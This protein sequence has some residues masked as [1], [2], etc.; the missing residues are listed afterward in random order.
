MIKAPLAFCILATLTLF[1]CGSSYGSTHE[2]VDGLFYRSPL[3]GK[4]NMSV[5]KN[6]VQV[7]AT[8][9]SD[10]FVAPSEEFEKQAVQQTLA[11][12]RHRRHFNAELVQEL[13]E[14]FE[15]FKNQTIS[16]YLKNKNEELL[17]MVAIT[18]AIYDR[19]S[20]P[21]PNLLAVEQGAHVQILPAEKILRA[22]PFPRPLNS[23]GQGVI[24]ELRY[25]YVE[26]TAD[27]SLIA[28]LHFHAMRIFNLVLSK[29]TGLNEQPIIYTY[30]S[31]TAVSMYSKYGYNLTK[32][33]VGDG[34][35]AKKSDMTHL[36]VA[37]PQNLA[38]HTLSRNHSSIAMLDSRHSEIK[39]QEL[40]DKITLNIN[41]RDFNI[42]RA[43]FN[44]EYI[45]NKGPLGQTQERSYV[46]GFKTHV[47]V[48]SDSVIGNEIQFDRKP[49]VV[50][51][52]K[53]GSKKISLYS[54]LLARDHK[55]KISSN[56]WLPLA[57]PIG[58]S[59][60]A[61]GRIEM[62]T[63]PLVSSFSDIS[64]SQGLVVGAGGL[65]AHSLFFYEDGTLAE[66]YIRSKPDYKF[67]VIFQG[68]P[69][70][71]T[72]NRY[73]DLTLQYNQLGQLVHIGPDVNGFRIHFQDDNSVVQ[74]K[75]SIGP[76]H[77]VLL[78]DLYLDELA[79]ALPL[80]ESEFSIDLDL[81][82]DF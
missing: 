60:Y 3:D 36:L 31:P 20:M 63:E 5:G 2:V 50:V 12:Y 67:K 64:K 65:T 52:N 70:V 19:D 32:T 25:Y 62:V 40:F 1:A 17:G 18:F 10:D 30:G 28:D 76:H 48:T 11:A 53:I 6:C 49:G 82:F 7:L 16:I 46:L 55:M 8:A 56:R 54:G 22:Q 39:E 59:L 74:H 71:M 78:E 33:W 79:T 26:K 72:L 45:E 80:K 38:E 81:G 4:I 24:A 66:I 29:V 77:E 75:S 37:T 15:I 43:M 27:S 14:N 69:A 34:G 23:Q 58:V 35:H 21:D 51:V 9:L 68:R 41:G 44:R 13:E 73:S 61:S 47:A 42:R 57:V